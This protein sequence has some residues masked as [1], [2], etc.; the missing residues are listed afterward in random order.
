MAAAASCSRSGRTRRRCCPSARTRCCGGGGRPGP[1]G[2]RREGLPGAVGGAGRAPSR[3]D[4]QRELVR[5]AARANGIATERQLR[6]YF[7]LPAEP[8]KAR[9]AELVEAGELTPVRVA[10]LPQQMYL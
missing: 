8:A 9:V 2:A 4:A 6:E 1:G 3:E 7:H 5:I 10:E